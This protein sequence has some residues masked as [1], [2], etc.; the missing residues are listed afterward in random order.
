[1]SD[2]SY[3]I[4]PL[5]IE[6]EMDWSQTDSEGNRKWPDKPEKEMVF[7]GELA[8]AHLLINDVIFLNSHHYEKEW[9]EEARK[10]T[11]L[12]VNCND[13]FAWGCADAEEISFEEV[14]SMYRIWKDNPTYGAALWCMIKRREMPQG[15]VADAMRKAGVDLDAFQK[16]HNLR[17]NFY[18]GFGFA[19][20]RAGIKHGDPDYTNV[21][22]QFIRDNDWEGDASFAISGG[23]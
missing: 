15:P 8:V 22:N 6:W 4:D 21:R 10:S 18:D 7:E 23:K 13:V 17:I 16:E 20:Q 19:L 2:V 5:N 14:E 9:T 3:T 11:A 12:L 1:M